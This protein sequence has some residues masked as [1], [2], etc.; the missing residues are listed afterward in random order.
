MHCSLRPSWKVSL[1]QTHLFALETV[2]D[3]EK[4]IWVAGL[5]LLVSCHSC[6]GGL[7]DFKVGWHTWGQTWMLEHHV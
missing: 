4:F 5:T 3:H 7:L 1:T 6:N 2:S